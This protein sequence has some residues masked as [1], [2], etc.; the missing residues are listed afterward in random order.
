MT[1]CTLKDGR[2]V[3]IR[4]VAPPDYPSLLDLLRA[5]ARADRGVVRTLAEYPQ[6]PEQERS[7]F[8]TWS[9]DASRQ[10]PRGCWFVAL[11][12]GRVV[13]EADIRR[14]APHRLR[15]V[16]HLGLSVHPGHQGRGLGRALMNTLLDW[17]AAQSTGALG[18]ITRLD[19]NVLADNDRAIVLYRSLGFEIEGRRRAFVRRE[20]GSLVDDLLMARLFDT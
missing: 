20:D 12:E 4:P 14:M 8:D 11:H 17:R 10:G 19:L 7:H 16:A 5:V 1:S 3:T 15:H 13:G 2:S 18:P 9:A 6:T